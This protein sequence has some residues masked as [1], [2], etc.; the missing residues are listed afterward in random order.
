MVWSFGWKKKYGCFGVVSLLVQG[1]VCLLYEQRLLWP[2]NVTK[3]ILGFSGHIYRPYII[4]FI[5]YYE[6][7][8]CSVR[9]GQLLRKGHDQQEEITPFHVGSDTLKTVW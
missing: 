2:E 7:Q 1:I 5:I 8:V 9:L 4:L 3:F 6:K